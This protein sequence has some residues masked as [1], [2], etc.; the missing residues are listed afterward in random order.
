MIRFKP[1]SFLILVGLVVSLLFQNCGETPVELSQFGS[2]TGDHSMVDIQG[3]LCL[4]PE[5]KLVSFF[6]VNM[7]MKPDFNSLQPDSDRDGLSDSFEIQKGFDPYDPRSR[8]RVLD[9][10]CFYLTQ[11]N[12]CEDLNIRCTGLENEMGF[13]DCDIK[14]LNLQINDAP[15]LGLDSDEDGIPDIVEI[16]YETDPAVDDSLLDYDNDNLTNI[17]EVL[18]GSHPRQ[19]R[20]TESQFADRLVTQK[21]ARQDTSCTGEEWIFDSKNHRVFKLNGQRDADLQKNH[22]WVLAL[23]EKA[24]TSLVVGRN[25]QYIKLELSPS[26]DHP[27]LNFTSEDFEL[28]QNDFFRGGQ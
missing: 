27:Q 26:L 17:A 16:L 22:I 4:E 8:G 7:S 5:F 25:M 20:S 24:Q 21:V 14:A 3:K 2:E 23:S 10:V 18:Q 28:G 13:S 12:S 9:G 19:E 1:L 6:I 15:Q 11:S